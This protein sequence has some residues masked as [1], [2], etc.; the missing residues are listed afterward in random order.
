MSMNED[1]MFKALLRNKPQQP[2]T[3]QTP[4]AKEVKPVVEKPSFSKNSEDAMFNVLLRNNPQQTKTLQK[5]QARPEPVL[6]PVL[7]PVH[8][9]E[10]TFTHAI[11]EVTPTVNTIQDKDSSESIDKLVSSMN[12]V[13]RLLK[14]AVIVLVLIL[15]VGIAVL[16]KLKP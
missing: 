2:K 6:V 13:Y 11:E 15:I 16:I 10:E 8:K 12:M 7:E 9:I 3:S 1:A 4:I 5:I 14:T